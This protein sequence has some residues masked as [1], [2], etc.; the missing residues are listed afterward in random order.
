[1]NQKRKKT[2]E[3]EERIIAMVTMAT[4]ETQTEDTI[5]QM[6]VTD[7]GETTTKSERESVLFKQHGS[8]QTLTHGSTF[9]A[10]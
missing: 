5:S 3:E 7:R 9:Q 2:V 8:V 4:G 6:I 1:M 10:T